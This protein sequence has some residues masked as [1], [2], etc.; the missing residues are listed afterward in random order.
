MK[1]LAGPK[2][3]SVAVNDISYIHITEKSVFLKDFSGREYALD[4]SL[5]HVQEL[6]DPA[7]FYRIN[8]DCIVNIESISQMTSYSSSRLKLT[9]KTEKDS[10]IFVVSR[11]KVGDFKRWIDR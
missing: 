2:Y 4:Y 1:V 11:D 3:R 10:G 7:K 8:R 5:D 6:L 9:L